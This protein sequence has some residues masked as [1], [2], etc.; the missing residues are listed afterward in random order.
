[1]YLSAYSTSICSDEMHLVTRNAGSQI[2]MTEDM[3]SIFDVKGCEILNNSGKRELVIMDEL[4]VLES[5]SVFFQQAVMRHISGNVPILGVI[6]PKRTEFLD[7]IR[8]H[9]HV[10]VREVTVEN[11]TEVFAW[12]SKQYGF[13][14]SL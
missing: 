13:A 6:K 7:T 10:E 14:M 9:T 11:R 12:L 2:I 8:A 5:K 3:I 1:M 4:G